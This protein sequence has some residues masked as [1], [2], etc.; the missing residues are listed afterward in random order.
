MTAKN[1]THF[2]RWFAS[3][4]ASGKKLGG[5]YTSEEGL[6]RTI[7]NLQHDHN[8]YLGVNPATVPNGIRHSASQVSL[9]RGILIDADPLHPNRYPDFYIGP[10]LS[11]LNESIRI[12]LGY[13]PSF[14]M[15][16]SGRG[17]Q[18]I[19]TVKDHPVPTTYDRQLW[20]SSVRSFL[21]DIKKHF[22]TLNTDFRIDL[23][24]SDLPRLHRAP[25][26][27]N[28]RTHRP[29]I[30][31]GHQI[32]PDIDGLKFIERFS[33][34]FS[35]HTHQI[36]VDRWWKAFPFLTVCARRFISEGVEEGERNDFAYKAAISLKEC[37]VSIEQ[38][39]IAI[40]KGAILCLP[41]LSQHEA[42]AAL[43]SAYKEPH[44]SR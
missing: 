6:R 18:F 16:D 26:T 7:H 19:L 5:S 23:A 28:F 15:I 12:I 37:G 33:E 17:F 40:M 24:T 42:E 14:Q 13:L 27:T 35:S 32:G 21:L 9:V 29:A 43:R 34:P 30:D 11:A 44:A 36:S 31:L 2:N 8:I 39:R 41:H 20:T 25:G 4:H 22:A 10:S 3:H 1:S 38:A